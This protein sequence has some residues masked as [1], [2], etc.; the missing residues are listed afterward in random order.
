MLAHCLITKELVQ[1]Q[2]IHQG[3]G[4]GATYS[5]R[6]WFRHILITK[7]LVQ[8]QVNQHRLV[9]LQPNNQGVGSQPIHQEV[10]SGAN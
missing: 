2:P 5:P 7:E 10:G 9:Q 1:L 3:V 6:S 8:L 4:S